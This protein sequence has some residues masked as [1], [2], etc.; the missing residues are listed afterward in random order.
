MRSGKQVA[1]YQ[2]QP[3]GEPVLSAVV[4]PV[5]PQV[6]ALA[7][8]TQVGPAVAG[9]VV[10]GAG[11]AQLR[12]LEGEGQRRPRPS[13]SDQVP[14]IGIY[15]LGSKLESL[16]RDCSV[17]TAIGNGF[18]LPTLTAARLDAA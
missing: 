14:T 15:R 4:R 10:V 9:R 6:A 18:S 11:C 2:L 16:M 17:H 13:H 1:Q 7:R 3:V 8:I 12:Q 5:V